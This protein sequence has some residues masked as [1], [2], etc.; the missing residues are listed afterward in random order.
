M[1]NPEF[2]PLAL[3]QHLQ[4]QNLAH[5]ENMV[6]VSEYMVAVSQQTDLNRQQMD[7]LF[8][9]LMSLNNIN[10]I[11]EQRIIALETQLQQS[12]NNN[13]LK[14]QDS[15]EEPSDGIR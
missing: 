13:S 6:N 8:S 14:A 11:L 1:I 10:R 9:M 15:N 4:E 5:A 3:L 2:D 7:N 12:I